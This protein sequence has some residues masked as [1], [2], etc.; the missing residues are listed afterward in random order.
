MTCLYSLS[1]KKILGKW[2]DETKR[3]MLIIFEQ[4]LP[5]KMI[6]QSKTLNHSFVTFIN[7]ICFYSFLKKIDGMWK[8]LHSKFLLIQIN[9]NSSVKAIIML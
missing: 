9:Y 5:I 2:V 3:L 7:K 8:D 6:T 1:H 4:N